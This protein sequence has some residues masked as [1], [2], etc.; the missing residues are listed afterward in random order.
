MLLGAC[1]GCYDERDILS[2]ALALLKLAVKEFVTAERYVAFLTAMLTASYYEETDAVITPLL[3][4]HNHQDLRRQDILQL[5]QFCVTN[6]HDVQSLAALPAAAEVNVAEA[7]DFMQLCFQDLP[8]TRYDE[9]TGS[10][11]S[12]EPKPRIYM[13][14]VLLALPAARSLTPDQVLQLLQ[15]ILQ[16]GSSISSLVLSSLLKLPAAQHIGPAGAEAVVLAALGKA[17]SAAWML[18]ALCCHLPACAAAFE[19]LDP[20]QLQQQL[21]AALAGNKNCGVSVCKLLQHPKLQQHL[22]GVLPMVLLAAFHSRPQQPVGVSPWCQS[23]PG[24]GYQGIQLTMTDKELQQLLHL[25]AAAGLSAPV[26][27]E[28]MALTAERM[29]GK[30]LQD[31]VRLPAAAQLEDGVVWGLLQQAAGHAS[32]AMADPELAAGAAASAAG[33]ATAATAGTAAQQ[34]QEKAA[35][36]SKVVQECLGS[37]SGPAVLFPLLQLPWAQLLPASTIRVLLQ[38]AVERQARPTFDRLMQLPQAPRGAVDVQ[39]LADALQASAR[40]GMQVPFLR[41]CIAGSSEEDEEWGEG[42]KGYRAW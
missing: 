16:A 26:I 32:T 11:Q 4:L 41:S 13:L 17:P 9:D 42:D 10:T 31:L 38:E 24:S 27:G 3:G 36:W 34:Q 20:Q 7:W 40:D 23:R 21:Q 29:G 5:L 8:A 30:L 35:S 37:D 2:R 19:A 14:E 39:L 18:D 33:T 12:D 6:G 1:S 28:L 15:Q 25:P 22:G